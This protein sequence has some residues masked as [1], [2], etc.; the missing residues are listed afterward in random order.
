M[1][2]LLGID[3]STAASAAAVLRADGLGFDVRP[4]PSRLGDPPAH[5]R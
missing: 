1:T 5:A 3:T 4:A 2:A